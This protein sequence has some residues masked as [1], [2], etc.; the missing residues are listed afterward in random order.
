[1]RTGKQHLGLPAFI[2]AVPDGIT[3]SAPF[4]KPK[5]T[6]AAAPLSAT[7]KPS[8]TKKSNGKVWQPYTNYER[9]IP[10]CSRKCRQ[11]LFSRGILQRNAGDKGRGTN[12]PTPARAYQNK[13]LLGVA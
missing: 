7:P 6:S 8:Q 5:A 3:S 2:G 9:A 4:T 12:P 1:M 13:C 11:G 10:K